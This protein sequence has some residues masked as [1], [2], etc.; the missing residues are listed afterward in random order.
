MF[1]TKLLSIIRS[2]DTVFTATGIC[3]TSCVECLLAT[4]LADSQ[5]T[6]MTNTNGFEHS[7]K[8]PDEG[9]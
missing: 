5:H 9:Q 6:S 1:R 8:T 2:L 3:Y 7:I 4:S